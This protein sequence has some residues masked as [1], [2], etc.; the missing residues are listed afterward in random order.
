VKEREEADRIRK[1]KLKKKISVEIN[2]DSD[3]S[4]SFISND[5]IKKEI[6]EVFG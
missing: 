1:E 4:L 2:S 6:N 3:E 5:D